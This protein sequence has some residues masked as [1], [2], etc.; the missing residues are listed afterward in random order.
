MSAELPQGLI[1]GIIIGV[2]VSAFGSLLQFLFAEWR[3]RK[4][5]RELY[6]RTRT[7]AYVRLQALGERLGVNASP[8]SVRIPEETCK[9]FQR[10]IED[11]FDILDDSTLSAWRFKKVTIEYSG[12]TPTYVVEMG[13]FFNDVRVHYE[14]F[15]KDT[16]YHDLAGMD[17]FGNPPRK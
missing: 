6:T 4:R 15:E 17:T 3:D 8:T 13:T 10:V 1:P 9:E 14:R 2:L 11:N 12:S 16:P 5:A 7:K